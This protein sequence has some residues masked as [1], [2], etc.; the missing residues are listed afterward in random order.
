MLRNAAT[1][2]TPQSCTSACQDWGLKAFALTTLSHSL[3]PALQFCSL[4][5]AL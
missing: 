2:T 4:L 5:Y 1:A 3:S